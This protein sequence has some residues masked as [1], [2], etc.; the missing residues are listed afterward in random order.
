MVL[1]TPD[2][3]QDAYTNIKDDAQSSGSSSVYIFVAPDAD[4]LCCVK[5]ITVCVNGYEQLR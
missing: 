3:F 4:A 2:Q 5:L 1:V